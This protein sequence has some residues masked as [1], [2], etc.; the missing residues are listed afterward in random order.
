MALLSA[1]AVGFARG[2]V[3][4]SEPSHL[5]TIGTVLERGSS[6]RVAARVGA[7]WGAGHAL[8]VLGVGLPLVLLGVSVPRSIASA[9]LLGVVLLMGFFAAQRLWLLARSSPATVDT[10]HDHDHEEA[11]LLRRSGWRALV[12]GALHGLSGSLGLSLLVVLPGGSAD[13]R[14]QGA[15]QVL[16]LALGAVAGMTT[17]TALVGAALKWLHRWPRVADRWIP[18]AASVVG[19]LFAVWL[20]VSWALY[21]AL[22]G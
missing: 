17:L 5:A 11:A 14:F 13:R 12:L 7:L 6:I 18:L 2:L 22:P 9:G 20:G 19:L 21:G 1:L 3:H 4:A 10:P 15:M 8:T 16:V